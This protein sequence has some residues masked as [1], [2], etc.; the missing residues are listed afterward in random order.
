LF[1]CHL[2]SFWAMATCYCLSLPVTT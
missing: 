2:S 1:V